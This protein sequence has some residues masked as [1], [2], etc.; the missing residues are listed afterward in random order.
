MGEISSLNEFDH[1]LVTVTDLQIRSSAN[2]SLDKLRIQDVSLKYLNKIKTFCKSFTSPYIFIS[3]HNK[4]I[5]QYMIGPMESQNILSNK[6]FQIDYKLYSCNR[7]EQA[8]SGTLVNIESLKETRY[9][10]N[11]YCNLTLTAPAENLRYQFYF[12]RFYLERSSTCGYDYIQFIF[13]GPNEPQYTLPK[14]CGSSLPASFVSNSSRVTVIFVTDYSINHDGYE[15]TYVINKDPLIK[16]GGEL[17]IDSGVITSP[18]FGQNY[19]ESGECTW[20]ITVMSNS[21]IKWKFTDLQL[22]NS[23]SV[24]TTCYSDTDF[25]KVSYDGQISKYCGYMVLVEEFSSS[26]PTMIVQYKSINGG[27]GAGFR[28]IWEAAKIF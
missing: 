11:L 6:R 28:L 13:G 23:T 19:Y 22:G 4:L 10:H 16:C 14:L 7:T 26:S 17:E 18:G 3:S 12:K 21:H 24:G 1:I 25:V 27:T 15:I 5:V 9:S 8:Y 2:C 20:K